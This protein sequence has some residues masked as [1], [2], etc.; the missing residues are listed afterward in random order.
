[1]GSI[2]PRIS[3]TGDAEAWCAGAVEVGSSFLQNHRTWYHWFWSVPIEWTLA[4]IPGPI[5]FWLGA[6][7]NS[8]SSIFSIMSFVLFVISLVIIRITLMP[9]ASIRIRQEDSSIRKYATEFAILVSIA[10]LIVG[11]VSLFLKSK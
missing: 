7:S 6:I 8:I 9:K 10:T 5:I 2:P 1:V 3:A 11:I 4:L